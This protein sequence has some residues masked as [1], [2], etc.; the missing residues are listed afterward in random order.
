M[1]RLAQI[2]ATLALVAVAV[3]FLAAGG[4][5]DGVRK[6]YVIELDSAFGL[7]KGGEFKVGGVRAGTTTGFELT[8]R[9]PYR[10]LVTAKVTEPGFDSLRADARCEVRQQ[11]L[12]GEYFVDCDTG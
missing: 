12:I 8:Q 5:G 7:V 9:E 6:T 1:R 3:L 4:G 2:S 10:V 11:S